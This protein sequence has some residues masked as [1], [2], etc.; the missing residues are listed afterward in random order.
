[1][2]KKE[3]K[4]RVLLGKPGLCG[5]DRGVL[6]LAMALRDAGMEVIYSGRHNSPEQIV[7]AAIQEDVDILGVS[8]LSG[9]HLSLCRRIGDLLCEKKAQDICFVVGGFIPDEDVPELKTMGVQEV[10]GVTSSIKDIT[11]YFSQ[12]AKNRRSKD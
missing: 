9:A 7:G 10:F 1:M 8:I 11:G 3:R 4:I 5:H 6:V 2:E 12:V